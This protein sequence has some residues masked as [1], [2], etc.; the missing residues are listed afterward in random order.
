M[1]ERLAKPHQ[2]KHT[3]T[4]T[5]TY[6]FALSSEDDDGLPFL[7][8]ALRFFEEQLETK[9]DFELVQTVTSAYPELVH[10]R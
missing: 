6:I 10:I 7:A 5:L 9:A 8:A 4:C 2:T 1:P 3:P